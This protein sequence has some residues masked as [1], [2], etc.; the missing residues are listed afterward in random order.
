MESQAKA[1][2]DTSEQDDNLMARRPS[3]NQS[4]ISRALRGAEKGG[5]RPSSCRINP[6]TGEIELTFGGD[7]AAGT[8]NSFDAIMSARR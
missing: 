1:C 8:A 3:F 2:P 6:V 5:M 7:A 4:D